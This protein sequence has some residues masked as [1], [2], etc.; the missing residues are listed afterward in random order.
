MSVSNKSRLEVQKA[1]I[2]AISNGLTSYG[3]TGWG[4]MEFANASFAK[5]DK[6]ILVNCVRAERL[7]WQ[8]NKYETNVSTGLL[9]RKDDWIEL[10]HWQIHSICKRKGIENADSILPEDMADWLITWFNGPG[11]EVLRKKGIV[12]ERI[13]FVNII[14]YN[15]DSDLYQKRAVFTVK[16]QVPKEQKTI[17]VA[18][19]DLAV[20]DVRPV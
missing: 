16:I 5:A 9:D 4:V 15:D 6:V 10:Q 7:G 12:N 1:L 13:D 8:G 17:G 3:I 18:P 19:V 2:E 14:V 20:P 11:S